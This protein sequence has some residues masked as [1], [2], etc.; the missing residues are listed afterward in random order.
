MNTPNSI[1]LAEL[2]ARRSPNPWVD[3]ASLKMSGHTEAA[4]AL[5]AEIRFRNEVDRVGFA[6]AIEGL[7]ENESL[8][9]A[10]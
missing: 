9:T 3:V 6:E 4:E 10:A 7:Q 1:A 8:D 2:L 5:A